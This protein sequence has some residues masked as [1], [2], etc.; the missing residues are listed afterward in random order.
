MQFFSEVCIFILIIDLWVCPEYFSPHGFNSV[1][2]SALNVTPRRLTSPCLHWHFKISGFF[3]TPKDSTSRSHHRHHHHHHH[4]YTFGVTIRSD[5]D[6]L[7]AS[8]TAGSKT[9]S[10]FHLDPHVASL[11]V[12]SVR[13]LDDPQQSKIMIRLT[14]CSTL[15]VS[16]R[17]S[18]LYQDSYNLEK[19]L[20]N[21]MVADYL[22]IYL[23][24]LVV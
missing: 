24:C 4:P 1:V 2:R 5:Y 23:F 17:F 13:S 7:T 10:F 20:C 11:Y 12:C 18:L 15:P 9:L 14:S 16:L 3:Q 8:Y 22:F 21:M 19:V 6:P